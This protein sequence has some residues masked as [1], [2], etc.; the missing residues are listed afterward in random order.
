MGL[1]DHLIPANSDAAPPGLP[2]ITVTPGSVEL[3]AIP[4]EGRQLLDAIAG[5]ESPGY[6][7]KYGGG[8]FTDFTDHPRDAVPIT[9]GPNAGRTSSAAGRYQFLGS[10]W[11]E[12]KKEAGLPDFSPDSQDA[13][14]W[15]LANKT[16]QQRTGRDL[17][18]DLQAAK[19]DPN[20]VRQIGQALSK[21]WTSLPGGQEPNRATASFASRYDG[22]GAPTEFS[23]QSRQPAQPFGLFNGLV[24]QGQ[25]AAP[26]ASGPS[27]V[28]AGGEPSQPAPIGV[29][30]EGLSNRLA[31]E[32]DSPPVATA[33]EAAKGGFLRSATF[34]FRDELNGLAAA[35]GLDPNDPDVV[36]AMAALVKGAYRKASGDPEADAA[37]RV[38]VSQ[39]RAEAQRQQEQQPG[40]ELLG[41][42]GGAVATLP[43][44]GGS[45]RGQFRARGRGQRMGRFLGS[46][47]AKTRLAGL[48]EE[49]PVAQQ[50]RRWA[51]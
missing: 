44:G 38:R 45:A 20:A 39:D 12:V 26:P 46:V 17:T 50:G 37:Y 13:G 10:T 24:P 16:Y 25:V 49:L 15:H 47:P 48:L 19:G 51:P 33:G 30:T 22:G 3:P 43:I 6:D 4:P 29:N 34:N 32:G 5:S 7:V 28:L 14:A 31:R 11:D 9:T 41:G 21:V 35:G 27:P 42:L 18:Q 1:F 8:K 40:A 23:A 36:N 2:R